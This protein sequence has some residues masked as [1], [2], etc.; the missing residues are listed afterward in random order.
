MSKD[1]IKTAVG[2]LPLWALVAL[3][4]YGIVALK[5]L[6]AQIKQD[7][8]TTLDNVDGIIEVRRIS[9]QN[10]AAISELKTIAVR[11][12]TLVENQRK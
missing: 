6:H 1:T 7:H 5:E 4:L 12:T 8:I 11:L 2:Q 9:E 10:S 3:A